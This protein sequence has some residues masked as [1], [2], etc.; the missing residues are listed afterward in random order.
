MHN[1]ILAVDTALNNVPGHI[2]IQGNHIRTAPSHPALAVPTC[3]FLRHAETLIDNG[4]AVIP[5]SPLTK[6]P[7]IYVGL[8]TE[9]Q[10]FRKLR[11]VADVN[12]HRKRYRVPPEAWLGGPEFSNLWE[13]QKVTNES[14]QE[15][16]KRFND[17]QRWLQNERRATGGFTNAGVVHDAF[18]IAIDYDDTDPVRVAAVRRRLDEVPGDPV[19]RVGAKGFARYYRIVGHEGVVSRMLK[20]RR[21]YGL[22]ILAS[23]RQSVV[24][25]RHPSGAEYSFTTPDTLL[26]TSIEQLQTITAEEVDALVDEFLPIEERVSDEHDDS[27]KA[28]ANSEEMKVLPMLPPLRRFQRQNLM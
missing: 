27:E 14:L 18:F 20:S 1:E 10:I 4:Y 8:Y 16:G 19:E 12:H 26:D 28:R 5:V 6:A 21:G 11:E 23:G 24:A 17:L 22:D 7:A 9:P 13:W 25:G 2:E 15:G 3:A